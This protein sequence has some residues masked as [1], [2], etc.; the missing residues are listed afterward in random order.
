MPG[1]FLLLFFSLPSLRVPYVVRTAVRSVEFE[2]ARLGSRVSLRIFS[3][4]GTSHSQLAA[5]RVF[6]AVSGDT[7]DHPVNQSFVLSPYHDP[8]IHARVISIQFSPTPSNYCNPHTLHTRNDSPTRDSEPSPA[9]MTKS[10]E[11]AKRA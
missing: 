3:A 7:D 4:Y 5:L 2:T 9:P 6:S 1:F 8:N 11:E 10:G